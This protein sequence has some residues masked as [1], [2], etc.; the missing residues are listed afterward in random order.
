M[1]LVPFPSNRDIGLLAARVG[2]GLTFMFLHGLPKLL[3]GPERW[4]RLGGAMGNLGINF[5]PTF[6]GFM[7]AIAEFGGGLL[8]ALGL[9]T[10]PA[11]LTLTFTMFVAALMHLNLPPDNPN[12][13]LKGASHAIEVGIAFIALFF[14]GP[15]RFSLDHLFGLVPREHTEA[16]ETSQL[17]DS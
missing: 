10:Q 15:G 1:K 4:E 13:G 11:L 5:A 2:L 16:P 9:V 8:L 6:W 14:T 12:S 3:G 17:S 7:A